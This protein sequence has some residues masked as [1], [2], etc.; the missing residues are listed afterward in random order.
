MS[1]IFNSKNRTVEP[2]ECNPLFTTKISYP[3]TIPEK[4]PT[5]INCILFKCH[6]LIS[7]EYKKLRQCMVYY[8]GFLLTA[9]RLNTKHCFNICNLV[10]RASKTPETGMKIYPIH[11]KNGSL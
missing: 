11:A 5:T 3:N 6:F 4:H 9:D 2:A 10:A 8:T 7:A 1:P